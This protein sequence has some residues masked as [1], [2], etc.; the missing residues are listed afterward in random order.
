MKA[1][2][3]QAW[4][5]LRVAWQTD[6]TGWGTDS[7]TSAPAWTWIK[8][9][10]W[11]CAAFGCMQAGESAW[12]NRSSHPRSTRNLTHHAVHILLRPQTV[13]IA[14]WWHLTG[15]TLS[16][17]SWKKN[18]NLKEC[19]LA[20]IWIF[21]INLTL[22]LEKG[23]NRPT[24]SRP[25]NETW[26]PNFEVTRAISYWPPGNPL[27]SSAAVFDS[28]SRRLTTYHFGASFVVGSDRTRRACV[29]QACA[30]TQTKASS[31]CTKNRVRDWPQAA[32]RFG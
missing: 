3:E 24:P 10:E 26:V 15:P 4:Q 5:A 8:E 7:H 6:K 11:S 28:S 22:E 27:P 13:M 19:F 2:L 14:S 31:W 16:V 17:R 21:A 20:L 18:E 32:R 1:L 30:C 9:K 23:R 25:P 29:T 12:V